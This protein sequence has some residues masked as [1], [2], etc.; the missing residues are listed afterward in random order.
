MKAGSH[1]SKNVQSAPELV[2]AQTQLQKRDAGKEKERKPAG[3]SGQKLEEEANRQ[4]YENTEE[5]RQWRNI[6]R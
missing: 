3:W 2:V 4:E 6:S 1:K 5:M